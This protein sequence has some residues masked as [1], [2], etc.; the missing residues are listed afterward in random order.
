MHFDSEVVSVPAPSRKELLTI[1]ILIVLGLLALLQFIWW[2]FLPGHMGHPLLYW[3]LTF[4]L[5]FKLLR[6]VHEW[7]HYAYISVPERPSLKRQY[8]VD[9]LTTAYPGE[10]FE[11]IV[12]TLEAIQGITYPHTAYLCDEGDDPALKAVC[13]RLGVIHVTRT[14]KVNA[15]AGN[16]NNALRQATGEI[17]VILDPDHIPAPDFLDRVLPYFD[18]EQIGYVQVVQAYYNQA[19]SLVA[20]GAAEQTYNFYGPMMMSMGHYGHAPGLTEDMHTAMLLHAK[21]WKSV[22]APEL[23]TRGL[24]PATLAAYYKQQIKWARGSFDL[25]LHIYPKVFRQLTGRQRLH[26]FTAPLY[27]LFGVIGLID[28]LIP[29]VSLVTGEFPWSVNFVD[30][31][32]RF[33]PVFLLSMLIRQYAQRWLLEEHEKGFHILGGLLRV[34]TWWVYTLGLIYTILGVTV[35]YIPTP[36]NDQPQNNFW[37]CLPN[38]L[39]VC[40]SLGAIG[41]AAY[42]YGFSLTI[43]LDALRDRH[44]PTF[45][46][47][48]AFMAAFALVNTVVLGFN[49]L[50]GQEKLLKSSYSFPNRKYYVRTFVKGLGKGIWNVQHNLYLLLRQYGFFLLIPLVGMIIYVSL[51]AYSLFPERDSQTERYSQL[52]NRPFLYGVYVPQM[53]KGNGFPRISALEKSLNTSFELISF[54]HAWS[55]DSTGFPAEQ[56]KLITS[57]GAQPMITWEPW[58]STFPEFKDDPELSRNRSVFRA[59][60]EGKFDTYLGRYVSLI[61]AQPTRVFIRFAHEADNPAYPWSAQGGNSPDEF[62]AAWRYVVTFFRKAGVNNVDWV[63]NPWSSTAFD[64]YYPG[65][66]YVDWIGITCLNYGSAAPDGQWRSFQSLYEPFQAQITGNKDSG[67]RNKP[68]MLTEFGS[69]ASGGSK[70]SWLDDALGRVANYPEIRSVVLFNSEKDANLARTNG[71]E[72]AKYIDWSV[73][74]LGTELTSIRQYLKKLLLASNQTTTQER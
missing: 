59:I 54:Y 44:V 64:Q 72:T 68:V 30:F 26:Y 62:I 49:V 43:W 69:T 65:S 51:T 15:K 39:A 67:I 8:T 36:K 48:A 73:E 13:Q 42:N 46:S 22:Y 11:M 27:Y 35:P 57:Q 52:K 74:P 17:C 25:L 71:P 55:P 33:L 1:R 29:A 3:P 31:M 19:E 7:Y 21:G 16:I 18:D 24:V 61:K 23:L 9:V 47:F 45:Y 10:P 32:L 40:I 34:G 5:F 53:D 28:L 41:Y 63:W 58:S 50:I 37:L 38:I 6:T 56:L 20:Y 60:A 70:V 66:P 12:T 14:E 2:F 4:S